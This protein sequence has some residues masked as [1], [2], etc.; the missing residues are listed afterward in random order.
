MPTVELSEEA[1]LDLKE[2]HSY[3]AED[4]LAAADALADEITERLLILAENPSA[5]R[6]RPE[7]GPE[8][9]SFPY[10]RYILF[11]I[12]ALNGIKILRVLHSARDIESQ[13]EM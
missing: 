3:I 13:F 1:R 8:L 2:I 11:Y 7:L 5:G 12:S 10:Q 4:N 9:R 6:R